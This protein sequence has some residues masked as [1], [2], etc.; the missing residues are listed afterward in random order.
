[1]LAAFVWIVADFDFFEC[2]G[3]I[4]FES[5]WVAW[6]RKARCSTAFS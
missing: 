2:W 3:G 6:F 1:M 4:V 5:D